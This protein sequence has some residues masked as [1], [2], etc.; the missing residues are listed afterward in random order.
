MC[1]SGDG[2]QLRKIR[3]KCFNVDMDGKNVSAKNIMLCNNPFIASL[4]STEVDVAIYNNISSYLIFTQS[5]TIR[6]H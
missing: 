6:E 4:L 2:T 5:Q 3:K 1:A